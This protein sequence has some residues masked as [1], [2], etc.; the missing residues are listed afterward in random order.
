MK[1][2]TIFFLFILLTTTGC[3]RQNQTADDLITVD[4]TKNS[5]PKKELI[6]QDFMDVEY[7]PLETNDEFVNQG[8]VQAV[9]EKYILVKN[10]RN[11]G[12]IF[13]YDRTGKAIRKINCKG[14]SGEEY[15]SLYTVTLDEENKEMF[16]N[17]ILGKKIVVYD[18]YGNFKRSFKHKN[19]TDSQFYSDIFNY[20]RQHLICYDEYDKELPFVLISKQDGSII[21]EIKI[22]FKEKKFLSQ[23]RKTGEN[24]G[25]AVI[26]VGPG[27]Y[28]S[29]FP[30][31]DNWLLSELSSDTVYTFMPDYNLRP[32]IVRTPSIQ[33]M[34]PEECL[35]LRLFSD[36]Y[37]FMESI[38]NVY[39][40]NA[41]EGFPS[42]YFVYDTKELSFSGYTIY[43]GDFLA[44]KEIYMSMIKPI[45]HEIT[46]WNSLEAYQLVESYNKGELKGK[47][48]EIASK[49]DEDSN[50]VIML[51]KH[52]NRS[53]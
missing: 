9:G 24:N 41:Q 45:N 14:Q 52:K 39:D 22:P 47:L 35:I 42:K 1:G 53:L 29:I 3:K 36:R 20:D 40:W 37:Y 48:K 51:I 19:G 17:D 15:I 33:S 32:F 12:D 11:D 18:L 26:G 21:Q 27:H 43:N 50:P 4:V 7:I 23:I 49:L 30:F 16:V 8:C 25:R 46:S 34:N 28:Y 10:Y 6:L 31:N 5:F 13:V 38:K 44:K 2:A